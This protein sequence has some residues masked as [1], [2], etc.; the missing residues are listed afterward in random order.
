MKVE[1]FELIHELTEEQIQQLLALYQNEWWTKGRNLKDVQRMLQFTD[2]IFVL[3]EKES[4]RLAAFARVLSD[5][6]YKVLI[7]DVI[8]APE[9]R[10]LKL[11]KKLMDE[12]LN[13]SELKN[14]RHVE[15]Y[16][17]PELVKFYERWGFTNDLGKVIFMRK[18]A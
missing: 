1:D 5:R 11:G 2:F 13:H 17:L 12:I 7:F 16:C 3:C 6:V 4:R 15:L 10:N 8:V 14:V 9:H 18:S